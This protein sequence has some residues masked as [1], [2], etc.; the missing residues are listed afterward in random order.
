MGSS[1]TGTEIFILIAALVPKQLDKEKKGKMRREEKEQST[2][3]NRTS[4]KSA[5]IW[6]TKRAVKNKEKN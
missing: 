1:R 5:M 6:Q 4:A 3:Y 2:C